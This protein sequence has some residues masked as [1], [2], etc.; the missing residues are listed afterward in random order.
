MHFTSVEGAMFT[1]D[2][3]KGFALPELV[4]GA[5]RLLRDALGRCISA[6]FSQNGVETAR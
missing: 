1:S 3:R 2:L 5:R 4:M 6:Q